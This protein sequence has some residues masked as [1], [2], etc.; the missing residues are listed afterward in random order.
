VYLRLFALSQKKTN[1][2]CCTAICLLTVVYELPIAYTAR[3]NVQTSTQRGKNLAV[4]RGEGWQREAPYHG[5]IGTMDNPALIVVCNVFLFSSY[6][7]NVTSYG[8]HMN[9]HV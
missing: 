1:Y 9:I 2:N 5:T 6:S 7:I 3:L 8:F 4:D